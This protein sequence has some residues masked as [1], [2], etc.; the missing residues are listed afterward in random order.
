[1]S[2]APGSWAMGLEDDAVAFNWTDRPAGLGVFA[3]PNRLVLPKA[4]V[5]SGAVVGWMG[6]PLDA[7]EGIGEETGT[8]TVI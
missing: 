7:I 5:N 1:M 2:L 6:I 8:A 4:D 3:S